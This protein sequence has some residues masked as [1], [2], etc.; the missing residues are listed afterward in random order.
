VA[1]DLVKREGLSMAEAAQVLGTTVSAVKLRTH[2][3]YEALRNALGTAPG[4]ID[5]LL[6][7]TKVRIHEGR[8]S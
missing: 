6:T 4:K 3:A 1:F 5:K 7:T 8:G 2:R